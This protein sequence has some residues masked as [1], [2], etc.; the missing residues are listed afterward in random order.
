[1]SA[2]DGLAP[3][4]LTRREREIL[5]LL[6]Q[7]LSGPEIAEQLTLGLSSVKSHIQHLYGKLGVNSKRQAIERARRLGLIDKVT[8]HAPTEPPIA[9]QSRQNL[10][11]QIT[12]F[13]GREQ[14]IVQVIDLVDEQALV[15]LTGSGGVGKTRLSLRVAEAMMARFPQG[16]WFVELAALA[17]PALVAQQVA[18]VVGARDNPNRTALENVAAYLSERETLLILDNCEHLL[19]A[20]AALAD[21]LLRICPRLR[22]LASSREPLAVYGEAVYRVPSLPAPTASDLPAGLALEQFAAVALFIDRARLLLPDYHLTVANAA[23]IARICQR[24]DGIPLAIE[25]AAARINLFSAEQLASRLADVFGLLT[26]G[27]RTALQRQ[28]TLRATIDW[29]YGLLNE[30][31]RLLLARLSVFA[32]GCTLDGAEG[33]CAGEGLE[34]REVLQV[35]S[36]LVA[37]SMVIS[38]RQ[39]DGEGRYS[40]LETIRQY[41]WDKLSKADEAPTF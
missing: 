8:S 39:G 3:E 34:A 10:P 22:V 2:N 37:K 23:A 41:A 4:P 16:V 6:A 28:Q 24:L 17:D 31:E 35:L 27:S 29:S 13:F 26:A 33:V 30:C 21:T 9:S 12:R 32:G 11:R 14:E 36:S 20:C 25:M 1:M 7:G 38:I 19:A 40:L 18:T 15:T 5:A